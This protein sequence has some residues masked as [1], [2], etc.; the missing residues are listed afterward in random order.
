M[1]AGP[2][3]LL[4]GSQ[5]VTRGGWGLASPPRREPT[6]SITCRLLSVATSRSRWCTWITGL[7]SRRSNLRLVWP[8]SA[9]NEPYIKPLEVCTVNPDLQTQGEPQTGVGICLK[10]NYCWTQ[11]QISQSRHPGRH[12]RPAASQEGTAP[13]GRASEAGWWPRPFPGPVWPWE[14]LSPGNTVSWTR[15]AGK[16]FEAGQHPT[17]RP[18]PGAPR[19]LGKWASARTRCSSIPPGPLRG[20][21][22]SPG[23]R[24][25][26]VDQGGGAAFQ[27]CYIGMLCRERAGGPSACPGFCRRSRS[28]SGGDSE[29]PVLHARYCRRQGEQETQP[30]AH[31]CCFLARWTWAA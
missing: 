19:R 12:H 5:M 18:V 14:R 8:K 23:P 11:T 15:L 2:C 31:S 20:K 30:G 13:V 28:S 27:R 22:D 17:C 10:S 6:S 16:H 29:E 4:L 25:W 21:G 7:F 3:V 1:K 9:L 24:E 26:S